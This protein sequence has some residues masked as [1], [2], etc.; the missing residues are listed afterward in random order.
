MLSFIS[1]WK[2][3]KTHQSPATAAIEEQQPDLW[4]IPWPGSKSHQDCQGEVGSS[5]DTSDQCAVR[6]GTPGATPAHQACEFITA[7]ERKYILP[8]GIKRSLSVSWLL[9]GRSISERTESFPPVGN[10][11]LVKGG[12]KSWFNL[13]FTYD[14]YHNFKWLIIKDKSMIIVYE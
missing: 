11:N 10:K 12:R 3:D 4:D 8:G 13:H 6:S 14:R 5:P 9:W 1:S 2:W 7:W